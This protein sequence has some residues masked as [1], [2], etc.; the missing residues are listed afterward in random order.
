[1]E[2]LPKYIQN[3]PWYYQNGKSS[4]PLSHHRRD[5]EQSGDLSIPQAGTG[6][7]D[8]YH[9]VDGHRVRG[10]SGAFDAKRDRWHGFDSTEWDHVLAQWNKTKKSAHQRKS[11]A[12]GASGAPEDSDDTDYELELCELG[13]SQ[14]QLH[15]KTAEDPIQKAIRER[16]DMPAYIRSITGNSGGKIRVGHDDAAIVTNDDGDFVAGNQQK[17]A[18]QVPQR[19]TNE[20]H[21][22]HEG[23]AGQ[24]IDEATPTLQMMKQREEQAK[25]KQAAEERKRGLLEKYG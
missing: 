5:P 14:D 8:T 11:G 1:M 19:G 23:Q 4:D 22:G 16:R 24:N 25:Q 6:I 18:W 17:F 13:L 15:K 21:V 3:V 10:E 9:V 20:G 12:S 2:H 7:N